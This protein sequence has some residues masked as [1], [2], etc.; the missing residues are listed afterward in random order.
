MV[1]EA[2]DIYK[3]VKIWIP[4]RITMAI[5]RSI[6]IRK[7]YLRSSLESKDYQIKQTEWDTYFNWHAKAYKRLQNSKT[8]LLKGSLQAASEKLK[9]Q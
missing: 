5:K 6:P 3:N 2:V 7:D 1:P 4:P 9:T 8:A